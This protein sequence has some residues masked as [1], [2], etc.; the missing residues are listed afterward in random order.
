MHELLP[1][2]AGDYMDVSDE[3]FRLFETQMYQRVADVYEL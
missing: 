2:V 1:L 3:T